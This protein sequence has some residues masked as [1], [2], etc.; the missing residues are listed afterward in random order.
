MFCPAKSN[1]AA[2]HK[3]CVFADGRFPTVSEKNWSVHE[4]VKD[5]Q[6]HMLGLGYV[7]RDQRIR[8]PQRSFA[9]KY[10]SE[11]GRKRIGRGSVHRAMGRK[12]PPRWN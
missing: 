5:L 11:R 3:V 7:A 6:T 2:N 4:D 10:T 1:F 12:R 9:S 8:V